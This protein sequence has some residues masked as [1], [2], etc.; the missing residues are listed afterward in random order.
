ML[1]SPVNVL[2]Y[3]YINICRR[4]NINNFSQSYDNIDCLVS[5][6][7]INTR[8]SWPSHILQLTDFH[9]RKRK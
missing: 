4:K 8:S 1:E 3:M 2:L 5:G 9:W 6:K 7:Q